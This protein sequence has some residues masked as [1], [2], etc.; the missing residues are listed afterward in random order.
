MAISGAIIKAP[1]KVLFP[2][3][4]AVFLSLSFF[5]WCIREILTVSVEATVRHPDPPSGQ[6]APIPLAARHARY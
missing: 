6:E 4:L 1:Q 3:V 2:L 5:L